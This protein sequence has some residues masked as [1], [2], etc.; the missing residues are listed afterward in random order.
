MLAGLSVDRLHTSCMS[1]SS[2]SSLILF[3]QIGPCKKQWWRS[4]CFNCIAYT[5]HLF[6]DSTGLPVVALSWLT[7]SLWWVIEDPFMDTWALR[8]FCWR[9]SNKSWKLVGNPRKSIGTHG[10]SIGNHRRSIENHRKSQENHRRSIG[11]HRKSIGKHKKS[12]GN[13]R[14]SRKSKGNHWKSIGNH[15]YM[16]QGLDQD[17]NLFTGP[18]PQ[19][20][21]VLLQRGVQIAKHVPK[22]GT[23]FRNKDK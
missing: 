18:E 21:C 9:K 2:F 8:A 7:T 14:K 1:A 17:C 22:R 19:E 5:M 23:P 16:L 3:F 12:I 10:K 11:N 20:V 13:Y 4:I 15:I 6:D